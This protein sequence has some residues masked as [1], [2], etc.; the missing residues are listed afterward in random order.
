MN[1]D[2]KTIS[3]K[4]KYMKMSE[5]QTIYRE[6]ISRDKKKIGDSKWLIKIRTEVIKRSNESWE[7]KNA[8]KNKQQMKL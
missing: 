5:I 1:I 3:D 7:E 6:I 2:K 8:R 4:L